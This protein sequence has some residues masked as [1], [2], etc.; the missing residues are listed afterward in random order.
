MSG[1]QRSGPFACMWL[2]FHWGLTLE[3]INKDFCDPLKQ[4]V[5]AAILIYNSTKMGFDRKSTH[6]GDDHRFDG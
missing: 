5:Y 4:T 1:H 3:W 2:C 6:F